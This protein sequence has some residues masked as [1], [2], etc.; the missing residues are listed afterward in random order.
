MYG[1]QKKIPDARYMFG[2]IGLWTPVHSSVTLDEDRF[3]STSR[4]YESVGIH[5]QN[6]FFI[7]KVSPLVANF[8]IGANWF[9]AEVLHSG[10]LAEGR[11][12]DFVAI[13]VSIGPEIVFPSTFPKNIFYLIGGGVD[14]N[15][16]DSKKKVGRGVEWGY[17]FHFNI[18][19]GVVELGLRF[20]SLSYI[21]TFGLQLGMRSDLLTLKQ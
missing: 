8:S 17:H 18:M 21:D 6:R 9:T 3:G 2:I 5:I 16:I 14:A 4:T 19:L 7:E 11:Y 13:P 12:D 20:S 15:I 1:Q 10:R